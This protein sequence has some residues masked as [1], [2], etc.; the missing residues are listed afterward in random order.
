MTN[1][2]ATV[3]LHALEPTGGE[4][5]RSAWGVTNQ[6]TGNV[7][8]NAAARSRSPAEQL[9]TPYV[10]ILLA[11]TAGHDRDRGLDRRHRPLPRARQRRSA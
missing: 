1:P 10:D 11:P 7:V 4:Q 3:T 8:G 2:A 6:D 9:D 5:G